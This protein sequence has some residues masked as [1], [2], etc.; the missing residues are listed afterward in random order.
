MEQRQRRRYQLTALVSFF[1]NGPDG[2]AFTSEG[3]TRDISMSGVFVRTSEML[4]AG[5]RVRVEICIPPL[6]LHGREARV[7]IPGR[8]VRTEEGGFAVAADTSLRLKFQEAPRPVRS[9]DK[10]P[11]KDANQDEARLL[12][13]LGISI[14]TI[15]IFAVSTCI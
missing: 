2:T 14:V 6:H 7:Q 5:S 9:A 15:A 3:H 12:F 1:W 11:E 8:V 4:S 13:H 10:Y